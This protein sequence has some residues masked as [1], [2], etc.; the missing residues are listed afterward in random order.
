LLDDLGRVPNLASLGIWSTGDAKITFKTAA[1]AGWVMMDD[2][3]I[4]DPSSG[5]TTRANSDCQALF[6]LLWPLNSGALVVGGAG[7]SGPA[8]WSAHKQLLLPK[9][10]G[11]SLAIGGPGTGLTNWPVGSW[12]GAETHTQVLTELASH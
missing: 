5:A 8:D 2:G 10:L 9:Q 6:V 12:N 3:T 7:A 11:R 4:G 1:D